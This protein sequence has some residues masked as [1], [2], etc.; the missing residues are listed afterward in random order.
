MHVSL[1]QTKGQWVHGE[2][3]LLMDEKLRACI[4]DENQASG[5]GPMGTC[6]ESKQPVHKDRLFDSDR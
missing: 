3:D 5:T 2:A 4:T 1:Q 6:L